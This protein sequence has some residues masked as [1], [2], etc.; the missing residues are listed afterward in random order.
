MVAQ[1]DPQEQKNRYEAQLRDAAAAQGDAHH[2]TRVFRAMLRASEALPARRLPTDRPVWV[3]SDLHLGHD[4]IIRYT[5]RPFANAAQMDECLYA[6]WGLSKAVEGVNEVLRPPL[7]EARSV[8][9]S[10]F[11]ESLF[12][13]GSGGLHRDQPLNEGREVR[14]TRRHL[15]SGAMPSSTS[16]GRSTKAGRLNPATPSP[17][18][19]ASGRRP[20][21][22]EGREVNR[23]FPLA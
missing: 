7:F 19:R 14:L 8:L 22:N 3:W 4:N 17:S 5:H 13:T 15:M 21:L 11:M 18:C 6:S 20:A 10:E 12:W 2:G 1:L 23:K 16:L 9:L